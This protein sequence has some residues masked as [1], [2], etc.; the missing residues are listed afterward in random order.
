MTY[1]I[2]FINAIFLI[3]LSLIKIS[4]ILNPIVFR[5]AAI[6]VNLLLVISHDISADICP[7]R[8]YMIERAF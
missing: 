2:R 1:H 5:E 7:L 6:V 8:S 4:Y 3:F